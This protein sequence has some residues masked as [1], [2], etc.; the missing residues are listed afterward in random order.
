MNPNM[1][2]EFEKLAKAFDEIE[3]PFLK[4]A[5]VRIAAL[6]YHSTREQRLQI[7]REEEQK[8]LENNY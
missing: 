7:I 1:Y 6:G 2:K 3:P 8:D 4:R 5:Q